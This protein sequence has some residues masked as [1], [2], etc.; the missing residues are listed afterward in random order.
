MLSLLLYYDVTINPS[1]ML[2]LLFYYDFS[3]NPS[4]IA[5]LIHRYLYTDLG[6]YCNPPSFNVFDPGSTVV[7][8]TTVPFTDNCTAT[9]ATCTFNFVVNDVVSP[10]ISC[11]T[12][13]TRGLDFNTNTYLLSY[14]IPVATDAVGVNGAVVCAPAPGILVAAGNTTVTCTASDKAINSANCSFR[15]LVADLQP[16]TVTCPVLTSQALPND[17]NNV[18]VTWTL[19]ASDNSGGAVDIVCSNRSGGNFSVGST[20]VT[21]VG[22]DPSNNTGNCSFAI[23]VVDITPPVI[24]CPSSNFSLSLDIGKA[25]KNYSYTAPVVYDNV[26]APPAVCIPLSGSLYPSGLTV[27]TCQTSDAAGYAYFS[28]LLPAHNLLLLLSLFRNSVFFFFPFFFILYIYIY[29]F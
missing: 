16:P 24:S 4:T 20:V 12:D 21:C 6:Y 5:L 2:S 26:G 15:I 25:T 19:F 18:S 3:T 11:P 9:T 8:C 10:T 22:T 23:T 14:G 27:T 29:I 1:T 28:Y 13:F 17:K 7:T